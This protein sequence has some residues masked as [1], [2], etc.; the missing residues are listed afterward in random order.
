MGKWDD[1]GQN[2]QVASDAIVCLVGSFVAT[3]QP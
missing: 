3:S 1:I 2:I